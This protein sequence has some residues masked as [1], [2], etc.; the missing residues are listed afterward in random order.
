LPQHYAE[1]EQVIPQNQATLTMD[2]VIHFLQ[3][4]NKSFYESSQSKFALERTQSENQRYL[5]RINELEQA[6]A[7]TEQQ[8]ETVQEDYQVFI[9]IMDRARKMTVLD[10][11]GSL[12]YLAFRMATNE[13]IEQVT[14][15]QK[16]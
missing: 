4:L 13:K 5:E 11:Q 1:D 6:L 7:K 8:L 3:T 9:Q 15:K 10:D 2:E 14:Q 16:Q 12:K